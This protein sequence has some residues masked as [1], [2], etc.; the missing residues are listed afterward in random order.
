MCKMV[1][2]GLGRDTGLQYFGSYFG[3]N[4]ENQMFSK[5]VKSTSC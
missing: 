5:T 4:G 2:I 1:T 3:E